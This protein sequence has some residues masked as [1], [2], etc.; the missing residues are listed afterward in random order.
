M[1]AQVRV[2]QLPRKVF[3]LLE[4]ILWNDGY[5]FLPQHLKRMQLSAQYFGFSF[6]RKAILTALED[7][8]KQLP[9]DARIKVRVLLERSG[10]LSVDPASVI[11]HAGTGKITISTIRV[12]S[13]DRLLRHKTTSR[14]LYD[15][16]YQLAVEQVYEDILF[17]NEFGEVT[18]GAISNIFI[19]NGGKWFTPPVACGLLPGIYRQHLLD[20][21]PAA[22]EK[23]LR[24]ED[25]TSADAV[26]ICN[27]VRGSRKVT[28][29][30]ST[31]S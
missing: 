11:E 31:S 13:V 2:S 19:E 9:S 27:A 23:T 24:L 4:S 8:G 21:K 25:L 29:V 12:S 30:P 5:R 6:D 3:Q 17:L 16:G 20:T 26:Y 15:Q 14:H 7:V 10:A 18:E 1:P 22:A 28:V